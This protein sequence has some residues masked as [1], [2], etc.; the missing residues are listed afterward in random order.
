MRG[1]QQDH[2]WIYTLAWP[3]NLFLQTVFFRSPDGGATTSLY[4]AASPEVTKDTNGGYYEP[5]AKLKKPSSEALKPEMPDR[6]WNWTEE[7]FA[8][9]NI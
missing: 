1:I 9:R 8:S 7:F 5:I 6:L 4:L 2:P 3:I